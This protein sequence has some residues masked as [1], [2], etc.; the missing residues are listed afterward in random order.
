MT[1]RAFFVSGPDRPV[2]SPPSAG[3]FMSVPREV[4]MTQ[5][6]LSYTVPDACA[7]IGVGRSTF[8]E[9]I[10]S[11]EIRTFKIGTRTLVP[12]SELVAFIERKM[13]E[14]A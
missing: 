11:G 13:K 7:Q 4:T 9:L 12:A 14:A 5:A 10:A 8:Y 2:P 1:R 3:F 6:K